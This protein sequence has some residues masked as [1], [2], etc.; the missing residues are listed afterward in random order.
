LLQKYTNWLSIKLD[1]YTKYYSGRLSTYKLD[2]TIV[3]VGAPRILAMSTGPASA[4]ASSCAYAAVAS[5]AATA[6]GAAPSCA[7]AATTSSVA[8]A[9]GSVLPWGAGGW[10]SSCAKSSSTVGAGLRLPAGSPTV[11]HSPSSP[12]STG[13]VGGTSCKQDSSV[14]SK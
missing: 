9:A 12:S 7:P 3:T 14:I 2:R 11:S 5:S 8:A 4:G 10:R 6:A 1:Y 13:S